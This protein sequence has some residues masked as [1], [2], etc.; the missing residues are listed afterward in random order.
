[1]STANSIMRTFFQAS[2][3]AVLC[4]LASAEYS[5]GKDINGLPFRKLG[6]NNENKFTI[7]QVTDLSLGVFDMEDPVFE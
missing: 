5:I 6:F 2:A 4:S 1:M 3:A 7:A